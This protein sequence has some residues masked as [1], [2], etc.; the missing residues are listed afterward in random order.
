MKGR[1]RI[2]VYVH[3]L[4]QLLCIDLKFLGNLR[5]SYKMYLF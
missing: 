2:G 1:S 4:N 3:R 5:F